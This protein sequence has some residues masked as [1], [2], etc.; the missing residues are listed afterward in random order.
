MNPLDVLIVGAGLLGAVV[1]YRLG[2]VTRVLSWAGLAVGLWI[3]V[4]FVDDV[5]EALSGN[6]PRT[7]LVVGL[8]FVGGLALIGQAI[9]F[10]AGGFVGSRIRLAGP[11][12]RVDR[13]AGAAAG[14][15]GVVILVWLATPALTASPGWPAEASRD[16]VLVRRLAAL[17]PDPPAGLEALARR[18]GRTGP[19]VF[20]R[21][22]DPPETGPPPTTNLAPDVDRRVRASTV[23][24][25]G[26]ACDVVQHGSGFVV[27]A[28]LVVTNA[29]VVAGERETRVITPDG[30]E[31]RARVSAFDP[32][33]DLALVTV[34]GLGL[35]PLARGDAGPG[36]I[37]A[38]YG[39]PG[40]GSLTPTPSRIE[41]Q[42]TAVGRDIYGDRATER[43]VFVLAA[44]LHAGDS[45]GPLVDE[46]GAAVG[47]AF[48]IDPGRPGTA[49]AL[50]GA[51]LDATLDR[52]TRSGVGT[53]PCLGG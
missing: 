29:H 22:V 48:A 33:R 1:G 13:A 19:E 3:A 10:A 45:G 14:I 12:R 47:V 39:Y 15:L 26:I 31:R 7:R 17:A 51:E 24:I 27:A 4:V 6:D 16:S 23:K 30:K 2:F 25:E 41:E 8:L 37:G 44:D 21:F 18:V 34:D 53:G 40:G 20:G 9:G 49:Y 42:I 11:V 52:G 5:T 46:S 36:V 43:D 35:D 28:D 32:A 38:V 50:T